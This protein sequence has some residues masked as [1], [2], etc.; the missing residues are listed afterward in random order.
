MKVA[1][2]SQDFYPMKGGI[3]SY[4]MSIHNKYFSK[5]EVLIIIPRNIGKIKDYNNFKFEIFQT[6]FK[7]FFSKDKRINESKIMIDKLK[8]FKPDLILFG[9]IRSHPEVSIEYKRNINPNVKIGIITHAKE[10]FFD[11]LEEITSTQQGNH[12]GY[13]LSEIEFYKNILNNVD[14]VFTVSNFTKKLLQKQSINNNIQ[15]LN[16]PLRMDILNNY[17]PYLDVKRNKNDIVI[18]SIGRLIKRKGHESVI[19]SVSKLVFKYQNLKYYIVGNGPELQNL[20]KLIIDLKLENN[21]KIFEDINDDSLGYFYSIADIFILNTSFIPPNDVEGLGIVFLEANLFKLP[22]IGGKSG[23]VVDAI[24]DGKTG[25]LIEPD[26]IDEITN[27]LESLILNQQKRLL[28]GNNGYN[29]A[30]KEFNDKP[31]NFIDKFKI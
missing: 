2:I 28:I 25:F 4:L 1:I 31:E 10:V 12:I 3:A 13:S 8:E 21:I 29:R 11:K 9:Y 5:D 16:P 19:N 17:S 15:I 27:K 20:K 22:T 26:N 7:P 14:I 30:I 23:G 18:L 24:I 6:D